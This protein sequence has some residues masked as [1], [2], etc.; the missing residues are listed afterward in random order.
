M[1]NPGAPGNP[2]KPAA[3][4]CSFYPEG[5]CMNVALPLPPSP[6]GDIDKAKATLGT[7]L[8]ALILL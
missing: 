3:S 4:V 8:K 6:T 7:P 2:D 5:V 1:G